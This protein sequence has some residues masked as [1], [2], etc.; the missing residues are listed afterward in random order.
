MNTEFLNHMKAHILIGFVC[1]FAWCI[2]DV[3][4]DISP[5][6][7]DLSGEWRVVLREDASTFDWSK[8]GWSAKRFTFPALSKRR[9][10]V[11]M[12][13]IRHCGLDRS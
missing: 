9:E 12:Y 11:M 8:R 2:V 6:T 10:W 5:P 7:L 13:R 1:L 3:R 4:A